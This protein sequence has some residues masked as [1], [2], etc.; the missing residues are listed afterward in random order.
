MGRLLPL[1]RA[2][3]RHGARQ[4]AGAQ[5]ADLRPDRRAGGGADGSS[6][7]KTIGG[8]RSFQDFYASA[9]CATRR[10]GAALADG[11]AGKVPRRAAH[12]FFVWLEDLCTE[13]DGGDALCDDLQIMHRLDGGREMPEEV[14]THLSGYRDSAPVRVGN[15]A[16]RQKQLDI[17]GRVV[18]AAWI[19]LEDPAAPVQPGFVCV[20]RHFAGWRPRRAG[21][22]PTRACGRRGASR[23]T[24]SRRS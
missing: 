24:S 12:A 22:S 6:L 19:C 2:V 15:G 17:Y 18:D 14:L 9:G 1:R 3:P 11:A 21:A 16:A 5:A 8:E 13:D 20:L 23:S 7:P 4:R 10:A